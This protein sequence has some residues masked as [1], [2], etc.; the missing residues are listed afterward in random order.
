MNF[1]MIFLLLWLGKLQVEV[2]I[3]TGTVRMNGDGGAKF[4]YM[5]HNMGI[6]IGSLDQYCHVSVFL[7]FYACPRSVMLVDDKMTERGL[8]AA[9]KKSGSQ[10]EEGGQG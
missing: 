2:C 3:F 8:S 1:F 9:G 6:I 7:M 4:S 5:L 10:S